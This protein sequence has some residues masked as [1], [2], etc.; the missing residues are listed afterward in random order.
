MTKFD[1]TE[2]TRERLIEAGYRVSNVMSNEIVHRANIDIYDAYIK[3]I[4]PKDGGTDVACELALALTY[5]RLLQMSIFATRAG[6]KEKTTP[7]SYTADRWQLLSELAEV[8]A[9]RIDLLRRG[10]SAEF[11]DARVNDI[12]GIYYETQYF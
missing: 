12:C 1:P 5:L 4:A 2:V 10:Y 11:P 8:C 3:P 6:A 9:M 7:Q